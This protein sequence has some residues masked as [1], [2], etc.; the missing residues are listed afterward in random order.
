M[1]EPSSSILTTD[2][3]RGKGSLS[4]FFYKALI[5]FT[6]TLPHHLPKGSLPNTVT[7]E[8]DTSIQII[9]VADEECEPSLKVSPR[10][11]HGHMVQ[12]IRNQSTAWFGI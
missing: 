2:G 3:G 8:V 1:T 7:L 5:P 12:T 4:D 6:R 9:A 10:M 11:S